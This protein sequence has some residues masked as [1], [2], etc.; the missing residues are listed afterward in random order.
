MIEV[1]MKAVV[2]VDWWPMRCVRC[3]HR[4][5]RPRVCDCVATNIG[6]LMIVITTVRT[7]IARKMFPGVVIPTGNRHPLYV[8]TKFHHFFLQVPT[9]NSP[10]LL[11]LCGM[12]QQILLCIYKHEVS[13]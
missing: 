4:Y 2:L 12:P 11:S 1:F 6:Y 9:Q 13:S 5:R 7:T 10:C 8:M 3:R